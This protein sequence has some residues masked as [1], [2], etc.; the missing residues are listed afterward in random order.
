MRLIFPAIAAAVAHVLEGGEGV[1]AREGLRRGSPG[2]VQGLGVSRGR[3]LGRDVE[4][5]RSLGRL[6]LLTGLLDVDAV[7]ATHQLDG[8]LVAGGLLPAG[9][10]GGDG[11]AL[12]SDRHLQAGLL[13]VPVLHHPLVAKAGAVRQELHGGVGAV[14]GGGRAEGQVDGVTQRS[15][16]APG[17]K[18][19]AGDTTQ[20]TPLSLYLLRLSPGE[21]SCLMMNGSKGSML[22]LRVKYF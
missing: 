15:A 3:V 8:D 22:A 14:P 16:G 5:A 2:L 11:A 7:P 20:Y 6:L 1:V 12:Q 9:P 13:P 4:R 18:K 10:P 21:R 17:G 19:S